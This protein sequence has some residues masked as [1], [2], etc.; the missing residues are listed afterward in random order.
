M[1]SNKHLTDVDSVKTGM[2]ARNGVHLDEGTMIDWR[3][4]AERRLTRL[5]EAEHDLSVVRDRLD[6]LQSSYRLLLQQS[7]ERLLR[8]RGLD[9]ELEKLRAA[10]L[11]QQSASR[12]WLAVLRQRIKRTMFF[13]I[14]LV[15]RVPLVKPVAKRLLRISPKLG[16]KLRARF[17]ASRQ[18]E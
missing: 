1:T 4:M 16:D 13:L 8:I 10:Q 14:G 3:E 17:L 18:P 11:Q 2:P 12:G 15:L 6:H 5:T 9:R 7:E